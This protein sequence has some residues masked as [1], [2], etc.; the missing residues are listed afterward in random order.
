MKVGLWDQLALCVCESP[1]SPLFNFWMPEPIFVK[2]GMVTEPIWTAYFMN[3]THQYV[4]LYTLLDNG[5][6]KTLLREQIHMQ[7]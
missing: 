7:Q 1:T 4:C 3:A 5:S 6:V 2:L